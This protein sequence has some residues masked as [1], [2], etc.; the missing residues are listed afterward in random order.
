VMGERFLL[1]QAVGN[2]L[3]NAVE[4]SSTGG[5]VQLEVVSQ[6]AAVRVAIADAGPGVPAFALEKVFDRFY[7]LPRPDTGR[8]SSGLGL[9]IVREIARLHGGEITLENR[10]EGGVLATLVLPR[11]G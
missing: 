1:E 3:Q 11:A 10:S 7:S 5:V 8:K 6:A 9:S 4:F 2:L